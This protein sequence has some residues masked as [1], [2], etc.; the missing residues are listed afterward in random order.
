MDSDGAGYSSFQ[1]QSSGLSDS[2]A[3]SVPETD[4]VASAGDIDEKNVGEEN[5]SH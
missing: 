2:K 5:I 4:S 1:R 3:S